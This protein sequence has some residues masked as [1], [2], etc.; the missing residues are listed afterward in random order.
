MFAEKQSF[1]YAPPPGIEKPFA[2]WQKPWEN[3]NWREPVFALLDWLLPPPGIEPG[4]QAVC[5][6]QLQ[7]NWF[8]L[9][10]PKVLFPGLFFLRKGRPQACILSTR[11]RERIGL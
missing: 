11:L 9:A 1:S 7:S 5:R 10:K 6:F 3:C 8:L 2:W 4:P